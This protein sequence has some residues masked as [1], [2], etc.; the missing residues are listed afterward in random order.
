MYKVGFIGVGG[1]AAGHLLADELIGLE[2]VAC[3]SAH[4]EKARAF[5]EKNGLR[6]YGSAEEMLKNEKLDMVH[7]ITP[8]V[9]RM[10]Y[11]QMVSDTGI[12]MCTVEKPIALGVDDWKAMMALESISK[13]KFAVS[14]QVRWQPNLKK[15]Q[16]AVRSGRIGLPALLD[17]SC[18]RNI[19]NQGT[20]A[21]DY[22]RSLIQ[23]AR[24]VKVFGNCSGWGDTDTNERYHPGPKATL[25]M[26]TFENGVR[27]FWTT[28]NIS[29][30]IFDP[31]HI[32]D[33]VPAGEPSMYGRNIRVA[34]H[35]E[36]GRVLYEEFGKWEIVTV[37]GS[38]YGDCGGFGGWKEN[39]IVA[40]AG[41]HK[42]LVDW[43]ERGIVSGTNLKDSLHEWSVVL[44]LYMSTLTS[45]PVDMASFDP[46]ADLIQQLKAKLG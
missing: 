12:P 4:T 1:R 37:N 23:N 27:G 44:A 24:V 8:P 22:G 36:K 5:A 46:P 21:L 2:P 43:H 26:L 34:A 19:T 33:P 39:N 15:C 45:A 31:S 3:C 11:M 6:D 17:M 9:V 29:P 13:T 30:T 25:A 40:Q 14:H 38:E 42:A 41:F 16:E 28:G 20:H 32:N 10:V 18:V 7:I 35:G